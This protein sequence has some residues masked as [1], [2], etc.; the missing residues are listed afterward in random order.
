M[1]QI[2]MIFARSESMALMISYYSIPFQIV[3]GGADALAKLRPFVISSSVSYSFW[4]LSV[5]AVATLKISY[6]R[7]DRCCSVVFSLCALSM[8]LFPEPIANFLANR[9]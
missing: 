3:A 5:Q 7:V 8:I 9:M 1:R 4:L 2:G 6:E